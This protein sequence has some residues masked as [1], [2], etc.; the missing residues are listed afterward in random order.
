[1]MLVT[2]SNAC[3][4]APR[5]QHDA[6]FLLEEALQAHHAEAVDDAARDERRVLVE[7][8]VVGFVFV[9][10]LLLMYSM[11]ISSLR[12]PLVVQPGFGFGARPSRSPLASRLSPLA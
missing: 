8:H 3:G 6:A 7:G 2:V 12:A 1:M 4:V 9:K 5:R 11:I 10:V